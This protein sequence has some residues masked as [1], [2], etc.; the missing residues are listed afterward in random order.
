[1]LATDPAGTWARALEAQLS[2]ITDAD[3]T[4]RTEKMA[5]DGVTSTWCATSREFT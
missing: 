1:M 2:P 4:A 3:I 5:A